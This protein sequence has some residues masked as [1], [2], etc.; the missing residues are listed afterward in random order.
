[1]ACAAANAPRVAVENPIG[2]LSR[3]WR[4]PDQMVQPWMFGDEAC[5]ETCF[6]LKGL[7]L[8]TP[9][10][11]VGRGNQVTFSSGRRMPSWYNLPPGPNRARLRSLT[12]PGMA[13]AMADQW[14]G[15]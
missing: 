12:F 5:K 13:K 2:A 6:W 15:I 11:I 7:P 8:L 3:L 14:G 4:K 9:T 10:E 1:M